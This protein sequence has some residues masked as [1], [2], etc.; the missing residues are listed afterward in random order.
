LEELQ[1]TLKGDDE[2]NLASECPFLMDI[3]SSFQDKENLYFE[4][5][6]I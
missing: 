4:L 6:Y 2:D 5:E 1:P 3:Y